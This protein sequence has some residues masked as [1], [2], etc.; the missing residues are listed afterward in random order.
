MAFITNKEIPVPR[1]GLN[2]VLL[3]HPALL[4]ELG[5]LL[6]LGSNV[7][8]LTLWSCPKCSKHYG[9]NYVVILAQV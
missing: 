1:T 8:I 7:I 3:A 2:I 9:K 5:H 4:L 6:P